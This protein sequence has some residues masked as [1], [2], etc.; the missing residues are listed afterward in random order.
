MNKFWPAMAMLVVLAILAWT[1]L[2]DE[3]FRLVAMA[4]LALFAVKIWVFR[5]KQASL[6][7]NK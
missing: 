2:V 6:P 4:V 1:T 7:D 3:R 5:K